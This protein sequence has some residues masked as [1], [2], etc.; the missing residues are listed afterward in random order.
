MNIP[1]PHVRFAPSPP[2]FT[3]KAWWMISSLIG[4][5]ETLWVSLNQ[6]LAARRFCKILEIM[7]NMPARGRI[8]VEE[9]Y[10]GA[11]GGLEDLTANVDADPQALK[12]AT[13]EFES[14]H[15]RY[16]LK[17]VMT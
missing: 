12:V 6:Y 16:F 15:I 9:L 7:R 13:S 2:Y 8:G 1:P 17:L 3:I 4:P 10:H 11:W 14:L 5:D